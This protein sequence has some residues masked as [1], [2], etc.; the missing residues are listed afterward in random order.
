[1]QQ[2]HFCLAATGAGWGVRFKLAVLN[3]CI[4]LVIADHVEVRA[5]SSRS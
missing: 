2:A 3:G 1:M 4:P 5:A